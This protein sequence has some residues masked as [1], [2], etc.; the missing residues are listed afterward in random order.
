MFQAIRDLAADWQTLLRRGL[1]RR[2]DGLIVYPLRAS[3]RHVPRS[4]GMIGNPRGSIVGR[5]DK[6]G[7]LVILTFVGEGML[8]K[9]VVREAGA[10]EAE[11]AKRH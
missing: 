1:A 5:I 2:R 4:I 10:N 9:K 3:R 6:N 7:M 11:D 8:D